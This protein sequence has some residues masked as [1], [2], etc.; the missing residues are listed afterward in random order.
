MNKMLKREVLNYISKSKH[1]VS[2]FEDD[3][4]DVV[5]QQIGRIVDIHPDRLF[6]LV[7]VKLPADY[8]QKDIRRWESLFERLSYNSQPLDKE[9]FQDYQLQYRFPNTAIPFTAYDKSEWMSKPQ[10]L[11]ELWNPTREFTELRIL[12]VP[13]IN[14]FI[15]PLST[16]SQLVSRIS[17]TRL[18]VPQVSSLLTTY[19]EKDQ[20]ERF[21]IIPYSEDIESAQLVYFPLMR[22]TTPLRMSE[23]SI[24]LL[25]KNSKLL[26]TLLQLDTPQPESTSIVRTRFYVPWVETDFGSAVRTRFEQI[27]YGLTV[28]KKT[29]YIGL[30]TS[31]DQVTRHKFFVEDS[32][33]KEPYIDMSMWNT[34]WTLTKPSRGKP[35]I[36]L[37][38]G[39]SKHHFDRIAIT[40]IDMVLSTYRPEDSK[41]TLEHLQKDLDTWLKSLDAILPFLNPLDINFERW[42]LQDLSFVAKYST[43]LD[44]FDLLRFNCISS[45]FDIADKSKSQFSLLRTDHSNDGLSAVEVKILSMMKEGRVQPTD[46]SE[47]L[48]IPVQVAKELITNVERRLEEDP[49]LGQKSFRGYPTLKVGSDFIVVSSVTNLK[50][51]SKYSDILRYV[52]SNP[53]SNEL[54]TVCPKRMEKVQ[55]DTSVVPTTTL[56]VDAELA[57]EYADLFGYAE[58]EEDISEDSTSV[59]ETVTSVHRISTDQRQGTIYNYFKNRLQKFDPETFHASATKYPKKCEQ[60]HQPIIL[61][62][63]DL[64]RLKDTEYTP[65]NNKDA[66][67]HVDVE[68]PDGTIVCPEYWCMRDQIPLQESQLENEDGELRCP[69]CHGALQKRSSDN[70]RD[71]PLVKRES[72][73]VYPGFTEYKSPK[74]SKHMPC[75]FKTSHEK[76]NKGETKAEADIYYVKG[77]T[78][79]ELEYPRIAFLSES[80]ISSLNIHEKYELLQGTSRRLQGAMSGFFR[81][82]LGHSSENLGKFL[83]IKTAIKP[84]RDSIDT[85]LKCSFLRTWK[86]VGTTHLDSIIASLKRLGY[87]D[88][89]VLENLSK[90]ISG[91][92]HA[93]EKKELTELQ[94]LEYSALSLQCDVF[95]IFLDTSSLGCMFYTPIIRPRSRGIIVLQNDDEIDILSHVTRKSRGFGFQANIF[96][97]PF[98]KETYVELEK[99]RNES[100]KTEIP[101]YN[102]ALNVMQEIGEDDYTIIL[103]PFGRGQAFYTSKKLLLPFQSTLLPDVAQAKINGYKDV[104][105]LPSYED[106]IALLDKAKKITKGYTF[107]EDLFNNDRQRV[108]IVTES[109]LRI[110]VIPT[111]SESREPSEVIETVRELDEAKLV[112]GDSSVSLRESSREVSYSSEVYEF[113]IFQ[114]TND[115]KHDYKEL[116]MSLQEVSPKRIQVEPLLQDW[117]DKV[118]KFVSLKQPTEFLSK[119]RT[120]CG[121]FTSKDSCTGNLCGWDTES[122]KC[123]IQIKQTIQKENLFHRLLSNLLDNPKIR[124]IVLDG[125]STPFFSTILYLELPHELIVTDME[126]PI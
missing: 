45:V 112:F 94:E 36:L 56:E 39:K 20:I 82:G 63:A 23:E 70:P 21:V 17:S 27:F 88:E 103:D 121:Q 61:S 51:S 124:A 109:G 32:K 68:N 12:G 19:F 104:D 44:D 95:R 86:V 37:Y 13:E 111:E 10:S 73:F 30:F 75:C 4:I 22:S 92:D 107:K 71:Y 62:E 58:Q 84:P 98:A 33:H 122:G 91:I 96:Q 50:L 99:L 29:P 53:T 76:K 43:K 110:P 31:K 11:E 24:R 117:F 35:T 113:L 6:V 115:I 2:F 102:D 97:S 59:A 34:W 57:D 100:C 46:V 64:E 52:L 40:A 14:S 18:P 38:R 69:V 54:D 126:L 125:R 118:T 66:S 120:P 85:I 106:T 87:T 79:T 67:K 119:I 105:P 16:T 1:S 9:P 47:E 89:L 48:S 3:S 81:V 72:G 77:E 90:L 83:D 114:L 26:Q 80:I 93:F 101:S 41:E 49:R 123:Q 25:E 42:E 74:N 5:R 108:E 60:K 65:R 78:K 15:V 116:R 7:A 55:A 28:S 8:Y